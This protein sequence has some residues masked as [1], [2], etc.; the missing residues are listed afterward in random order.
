MTT[1][2]ELL[3][4]IAEDWT[5]N[6]TSSLFHWDVRH[7]IPNETAD[8]N[9]NLLAVLHVNGKSEVIKGNKTFE[10]DCSLTGQVLI[11]EYTNEQVLNEVKELEL[12]VSNWCSEKHYTEILDAVLIEA[13]T[14]TNDVSI[15]GVYLTFN[16]PMTFIVQL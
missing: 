13:M 6:Q 15:D 8:E 3:K 4:E 11:A 1:L 9:K 7:E 10:V 5:K 16:L 2:T 12:F 14:E